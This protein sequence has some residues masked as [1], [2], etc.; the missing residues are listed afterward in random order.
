LCLS[1][2]S[3]LND[4][5]VRVNDKSGLHVL[6]RIP[7]RFVQSGAILFVEPISRIERQQLDFGAFGQIRRFINH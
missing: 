3:K 5:G 1:T 7:Q 4:Y 6:F 2:R